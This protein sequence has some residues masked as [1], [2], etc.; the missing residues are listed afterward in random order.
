MTNMSKQ[1]RYLSLIIKYFWI[2]LVIG[3]ILLAGIFTY[4]SKTQMP[5]TEELENPNFEYASIIYD[6]NIEEIGRYYKFNRE[7]V[8]YE[9]LNPHIVN[10]LIATEDERYHNHSGIDPKGTVRAFAYLGT[11]GGASTITQQLAKLFFTDRARSK[12]QRLTQK[13]KEWAI[14]V[15]LEKRY[16][17]EEI[18][19]M[20][21][22]KFEFINGAHGIQAAAQTYFGKTQD[23]LSIEE[24]A[25]LVGMLQNPSRFNPMR[26]LERSTHRRNI[27]LAQMVRNNLLKQS[28][29][30]KIKE[31]P[32]DISNFKRDVHYGGVAPY[33]RSSLKGYL[34]NILKQEQHLKSDGTKYDIYKDGLKIY[35]TLNIKMQ[36]HAEAARSEHMKKIQSTYFKVWKGKD[37]WTHD[38]TDVQKK[39][40]LD[41]LN[42]KVRDSDRFL[43]MRSRYLTKVSTKIMSD[44][45][46]ARLWDTDLIRMLKIAK[47]SK[48]SNELLSKSIINRGQ[49]SVYKGIIASAHWQELKTQWNALNKDAKSS[50]NKS[51]KMTVYDY[52][53]GKEKS[54]SMTPMDSIRYHNMHMQ[55][56]SVSIDPNTV[57]FQFKI[58]NIPY[59]QGIQILV[60]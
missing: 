14:A 54:T 23:K 45:P 8:Y 40:R 42:K 5:D 19:A 29:F 30:D 41:A 57:V 34:N 47:D 35:T 7:W 13:L 44:F 39:I 53:T 1:A 46:K 50:F 26:F 58:S 18:L 38:A 43:R 11:K 15:Q 59:Q 21:L 52:E 17:K 25:V 55:L 51:V 56:G 4:I 31:V 10:A 49:A 27:V 12:F 2:A 24:S 48:Y 33:F 3:L 6:E 36:K 32:I 60:S 28:D 22:N 9:S 20:Y 16:T 37:P